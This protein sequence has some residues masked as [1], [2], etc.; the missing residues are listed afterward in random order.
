MIVCCGAD[1]I[2]LALLSTLPSL[3]G[4][5]RFE[6]PGVYARVSAV[7][8]WIE[9][10]KCDASDFP[11]DHCTTLE[12]EITFDNNPEETGYTIVDTNHPEK[13][14][15]VYVPPGSIPSAKA[16]DTITLR[17]QVPIGNYALQ[18]EDIDGF[19]CQNGMG[20]IVV[21][22]GNREYTVSGDFLGGSTSVDLPNVGIPDPAEPGNGSGSG[23]GASNSVEVNTVAPG[24]QGYGIEIIIMYELAKV[25]DITWSIYKQAEGSTE[26]L[27]LHQDTPADFG[28]HRVLDKYN[29]QIEF[30]HDLPAG[31]YQLHIEDSTGQGM[32]PGTGFVSLFSIDNVSGKLTGRLYQ[33]GGENIGLLTKARFV[34]G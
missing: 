7:D 17:H 13:Q 4:C 24:Q 27:L 8:R 34:L 14:A 11:P 19:C 23:N 26:L 15:M 31:M 2:M 32:S 6:R 25:R 5:A 33:N 1:N 29:R 3:S 9:H 28:T 16:G 22:D 20:E 18:V 30:F 10:L 21:T 12:V